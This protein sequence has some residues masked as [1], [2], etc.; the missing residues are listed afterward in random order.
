[1]QIPGQLS[2]GSEQ[3]HDRR[4]LSQ[5]T[6]VKRDWII[7][8]DCPFQLY[9]C[10]SKYSK[11]HVCKFTR[12]SHTIEQV[13]VPLTPHSTYICK[14]KQQKS[15]L[16]K[17]IQHKVGL[18]RYIPLRLHICLITLIELPFSKKDIKLSVNTLKWLNTFTP[19]CEIHFSPKKHI[20]APYII[21]PLTV[22]CQH[23]LIFNIEIST[24]VARVKAM[25]FP[26]V[27]YQWESWTIKKTEHR[28]TDAF[29]L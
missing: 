23:I 26:V 19:L 16:H 1:M 25:V 17:G 20:W 13:D 5:W 3:C 2:R 4:S 12:N 28:R 22:S 14:T 8:T 15:Y 6:Q 29:D 18:I 7:S 21:N 9:A 27:M 11:S 24:K 10:D